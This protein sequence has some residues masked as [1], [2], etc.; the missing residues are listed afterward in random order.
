VKRRSPQSGQARAPGPRFDEA[1]LLARF[2][3]DAR[4]TAKLARLFL[5]DQSRLMANIEKAVAGRDSAKLAR[6]AHELKG[7]V[8]NFGAARAVEAAGK[9]EAMAWA[10]ELDSAE[11]VLATLR[12]EVAAV[13]RVLATLAKKFQPGSGAR[14]KAKRRKK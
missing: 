13:T 12:V 1:A 2:K 4:L 5:A 6:A 11:K 14:R 3:G 7:A 9:L 10:D 8:G